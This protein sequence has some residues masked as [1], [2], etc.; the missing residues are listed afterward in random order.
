MRVLTS[1]YGKAQ[2]LRKENILVVNI[3]VMK[4]NWFF[5]ISYEKLFPER[6]MLKLDEVEY[7]K[8]YETILSRLAPMQV[9]RDLDTMMRNYGASGVALVCWEKPERFCHRHLVSKW[10]KEKLGMDVKEY[11]YIPKR[12]QSVTQF[13]LFG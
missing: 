13:N 3:A 7:T 6:G 8:R 12:E 4:P 5:G 10:F 9:Y 2:K 1:Y 11:D